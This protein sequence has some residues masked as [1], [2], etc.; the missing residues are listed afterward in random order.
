MHVVAKEDEHAEDIRPAAERL[1]R[2]TNQGL[3][4]NWHRM[5]VRKPA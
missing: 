1:A 4:D 2:L 3:I 5:L